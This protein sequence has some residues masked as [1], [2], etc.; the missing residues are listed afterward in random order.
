MQNPQD[1]KERRTALVLDFSPTILE[2]FSVILSR[3]E[4]DAKCVDSSETALSLIEK[5]HIDIA[6][7]RLE[8]EGARDVIDVLCQKHVPVIIFSTGDKDKIKA[9]ADQVGAAGWIQG[10]FKLSELTD[11]I[12]NLVNPS[13]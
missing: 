6:L 10:P 8:V 12:A 13:P 5:E 9:V 1:T 4:F 11:M 3:I 2:L 7:V